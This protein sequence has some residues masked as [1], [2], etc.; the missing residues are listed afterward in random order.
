[1]NCGNIVEAPSR[2]S[3]RYEFDRAPRRCT[4]PRCDLSRTCRGKS[5]RER[6]A[7]H[8]RQDFAAIG[9]RH[10]SQARD[11]SDDGRA[12]FSAGHRGTSS[13]KPGFAPLPRKLAALSASARQRLPL[14]DGESMARL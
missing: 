4:A 2:A 13:V 7:A 8:R 11:R 6:A 3:V 1:M 9:A 14:R 10:G 12:S 5:E